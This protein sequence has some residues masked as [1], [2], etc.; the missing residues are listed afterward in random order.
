[1][2]TLATRYLRLIPP[3]MHVHAHT[4]R[5][6]SRVS[7]KSR[8]RV[9]S[10]ESRRLVSSHLSQACGHTCV[11]VNLRMSVRAC[12]CVC[13]S[14]RGCLCVRAR[15]CMSERDFVSC[16]GIPDQTLKIPIR[17]FANHMFSTMFPPDRIAID[18]F[19]RWLTFCG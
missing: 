12:T 19:T 8:A 1:M 6:S 10:D 16:L 14:V 11:W 3:A 7:R 18:S 4:S 17:D 15:M 5:L 2:Q 13:E 9:L